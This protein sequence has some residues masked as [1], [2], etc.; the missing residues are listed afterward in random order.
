MTNYED[1]R[2]EYTM[3]A[4]LYRQMCYSSSGLTLK[5]DSNM[6]KISP[7]MGE[8][9]K[10][11]AK[12]LTKAVGKGFGTGLKVGGAAALG[13]GTAGYGSAPPALVAQ[14]FEGPVVNYYSS[15]GGNGVLGKMIVVDTDGNFETTAD[16]KHIYMY[17]EN[18]AKHPELAVEDPRP[19]VRF[20]GDFYDDKYG[21]GVYQRIILINGKIIQH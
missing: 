20:H 16:Q 10:K 6:K 4:G 14:T 17:N 13:L 9:A 18:F 19:V 11:A 21:W 12:F 8:V 5:E 1:K 3:L 2:Q 15:T 7:K